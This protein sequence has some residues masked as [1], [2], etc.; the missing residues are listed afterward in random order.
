MEENN[1]ILESN[2]CPIKIKKKKK[3]SEGKPH[4]EQKDTVPSVKRLALRG[5]SI[6]APRKM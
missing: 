2:Y 6:S 3:D 1:T 5:H 4:S